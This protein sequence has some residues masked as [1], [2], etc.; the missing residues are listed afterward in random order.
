[1]SRVVG[2]QDCSERQ[3]VRRNHHV[4]FANELTGSSE[5]VPDV[6]IKF[7][8]PLIPGKHSNCTQKERHVGL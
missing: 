1:M 3:G 2:D 7:S 8:A 6:G 5:I 4:E